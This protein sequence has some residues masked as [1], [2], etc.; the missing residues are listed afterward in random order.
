MMWHTH[1]AI[2]ASATCLLLPFVPPDGSATIALLLVFCVMGAMV[3]DLDAVES[4]IKH[5]KVMGIKPLVPVSRAIN[6]EFGHRG[7]LHSLRGWL[8]WT[9]LIV[10]LGAG[11]GWLPVA[12]LSLGYASHLAGDACTR[13][14]IPMFYPNRRP[15]HL[16]PVS[17]RVVTG[18]DYEELFFVV[19]ALLDVCL[20]MAQLMAYNS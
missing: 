2:G 14:G 3:P 16:L 5:F 1:A 7:L 11:I 8:I 13:T 6:R 15:F 12:A 18:S 4:K 17:I 9:A 10:P 19:L 20:L